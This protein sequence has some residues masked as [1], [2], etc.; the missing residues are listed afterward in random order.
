MTKTPQAPKRILLIGRDYF[1]YT[2]AIADVL[3]SHIGAEVD[4][5]TIEPG[6]RLYNFARRIPALAGLWQDWHH[7]AA[8]KR[9]AS[10]GYDLLICIQVHQ[11]EHRMAWYKAR[12]PDV[13]ALL[14]YW[15]SLTTHDYRP[16]LPHFDAVFTFDPEDAAQH[17]ELAYLPLFFTPEFRKLRAAGPRPYDLSFVGTAVSRTR[18]DQLTALREAAAKQGLILFDYLLVSPF[19]YLRELLAGRR[20]RRVHFRPMGHDEVMRAYAQAEAVLDLPN[21]R[22]TGFTMRTFETIGAHRK[23]VTTNQRAATA[24][25]HSPETVCV[26]DARAIFPT[27]DWMRTEAA[28]PTAVEGFSLEAWAETLLGVN[29]TPVPID[30]VDR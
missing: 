24:P 9:L 11:L 21:N 18:Y 22:Q 29:R 26:M 16:W 4:F 2:R 13:R 5:V 28:F 25:F 12:F 15:D 14:Y 10:K 27:R 6:S 7:R 20:L 17:G 8:L 19:F 30:E 3:R 1:F 23:L